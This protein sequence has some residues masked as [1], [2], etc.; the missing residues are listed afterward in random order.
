MSRLYSDV[1]KGLEPYTPGEQLNDKRYI[2][3]NTNENPYPPS[4]KVIDSI[5]EFANSDLR[6]YPDPKAR[7][8]TDA[9]SEKYSVEAKNIF[10]GN[11]SDEV[12]AMAFD[13]FYA[14]KQVAFP[15]LT[16]SF[17]PVYCSL[18]DIDAVKVKMKDRFAIDKEALLS[19]DMGKAF[20][21]PNA[22]TGELIE[23]EYIISLL[24]KNKDDVMLIDEAY[25]DFADHDESMIPYI[26]QFDNLLVV[27]TFSKSYS[28]AGMRIGY[29]IGNEELIKGLE[30]VKNSFNSYP[31][32][33]IAQAAGTEAVKDRAYFDDINTRVVKTRKRTAKVLKDMGCAVLPSESNFLLVSFK[34]YTSL[35]IYTKFREKGI[36][37]RQFR[38][39]KDHVRIS[40]GTDEDMD[41][42]LRYAKEILT[43]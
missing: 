3:L 14:K 8:L 6:L 17:Y 27:R 36:L 19:L 9:L 7:I 4:K 15:E 28:L 12:L 38:S 42:L 26:R 21:N 22:P 35:E 25:M 10:I 13:A 2:K 16:Y 33:R 30:M 43:K 20:A 23:R 39:M 5:K 24:E 34:G 40:I 32:D 31:V 18:F 11:G 29:A 1:L 37:I 41:T